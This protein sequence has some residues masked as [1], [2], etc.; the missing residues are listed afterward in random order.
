MWKRFLVDF[1][2]QKRKT[3]YIYIVELVNTSLGH[4]EDSQCRR[5]KLWKCVSTEVVSLELG[6]QQ[7]RDDVWR[8]TVNEAY[9][10]T[11]NNR[12]HSPRL[13][14]F[15]IGKKPDVEIRG[16]EGTVKREHERETERNHVACRILK[17]G[18][19]S[20]VSF[21]W[22]CV[23]TSCVIDFRSLYYRK[24]KNRWHHVRATDLLIASCF[25]LVINSIDCTNA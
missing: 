11:S 16:G 18:E 8:L 17:N 21:Q 6:T 23:C 4:T 1:G 15:P 12:W 22:T 13:F 20:Y 7:A 3:C 19:Q 14:T 5:E 10:R 2:T 24:K 25:S 9:L